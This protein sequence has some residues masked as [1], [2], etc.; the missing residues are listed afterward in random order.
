MEEEGGIRGKVK[1]DEEAGRGDV[2]GREGRKEK[3]RKNRRKG[4]KIK[5]ERKGK[6]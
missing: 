5:S 2:K 1:Q 3:G 6:G 4:N